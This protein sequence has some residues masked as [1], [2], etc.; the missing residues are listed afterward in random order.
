MLAIIFFN[1]V[2]S[3]SRVRVSFLLLLIMFI[4]FFFT[5]CLQSTGVCRLCGDS[6]GT[7]YTVGWACK[8]R[9]TGWP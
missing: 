5:V 3:R 6:V 7:L 4:C 2:I 8:C 9:Q 1:A